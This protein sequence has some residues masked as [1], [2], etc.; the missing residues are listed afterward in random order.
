LERHTPRR[1]YFCFCS[2][3]VLTDSDRFDPPDAVTGAD[4]F[5][6]SIGSVVAELELEAE[7]LLFDMVHHR[8]EIVAGWG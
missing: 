5:R 7:I 8:L 1:L 2:R 3:L 6:S 4:R